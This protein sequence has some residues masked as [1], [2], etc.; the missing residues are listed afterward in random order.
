V[1]EFVYNEGGDVLW[2]EALR[3]PKQEV[4]W[5]CAQKGD[6]LWERLQVD[7]KWADEYALA[8][9]TEYFSLYRLKR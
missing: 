1:K 4:G 6:V 9:K 3:N 8:V 7:P 2:S 5:I